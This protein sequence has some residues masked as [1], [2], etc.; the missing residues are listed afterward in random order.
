MHC[1]IFIENMPDLHC[2]LLTPFEFCIICRQCMSPMCWCCGTILFESLCCFVSFM[3]PLHHNIII[4]CCCLHVCSMYPS[5]L[6]SLHQWDN[7]ELD[8]KKT[9]VNGIALKY[10]MLL[11]LDCTSA[12]IYLFYLLA[13]LKVLFLCTCQC[14]RQINI[15]LCT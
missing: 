11:V 15:C 5:V 3:V 2:H 4:L 1:G 12:F 8:N 14:M 6:I 10:V 13:V 9:R 7:S